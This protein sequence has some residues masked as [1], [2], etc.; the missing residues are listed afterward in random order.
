M[1]ASTAKQVIK[2]K[3]SFINITPTERSIDSQSAREL[4][5]LRLI[6]EITPK[7]NFGQI[8]IKLA[9]SALEMWNRWIK[10]GEDNAQSEIEKLAEK[11]VSAIE[12]ILD[13]PELPRNVING[14][15]I[16]DDEQDGYYSTRGG[17]SRYNVGIE[18]EK[19][20]RNGSLRHEYSRQ[21]LPACQNISEILNVIENN[22]ITVLCGETGQHIFYCEIVM[23]LLV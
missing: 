7:S 1:S 8:S 21:N 22:E 23:I 5:C 17:M 15:Q 4:A 9:P 16:G 13:M 12:K 11:H 19:R 20:I 6:F 10:Q 3:G 14:K 18:M 2:S